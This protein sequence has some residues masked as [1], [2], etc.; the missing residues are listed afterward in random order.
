MKKFNNY[1]CWGLFLNG[2]F[3]FSSRF[4]LLPDFIEG[5]SV[6]LG[7]LF[8][9]IGISCEKYDI[10]KVRNYKKN[11]FKSIATNISLLIEN[12]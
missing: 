1:I 8:I 7:L 11:L 9:L 3:I 12:G 10:S 4:N 2:I 5:I 6:G